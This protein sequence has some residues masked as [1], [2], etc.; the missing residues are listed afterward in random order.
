MI[1]DRVTI[2]KVVAPHGVRGDVRIAV[3]SDFPERFLDLDKVYL[4]NGTKLIVEDARLHKQFVLLKFSGLDTMNDV[5]ALRGRY[6]QVNR[7]DVVVL[8]EG[9]YYFFDIIGLEV[10]TVDGD[11]LGIITDILKTGSNDVYVTET[12]G[13]K[14]I[15]VPALKE[16]VRSIDIPGKKMIVKLQEEWDDNED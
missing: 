8:P 3:L 13:K 4:D 14:P 7:E 5:E 16:V 6:I 11:K 12:K 15:L 1:I 2:G 9:H 10:Y